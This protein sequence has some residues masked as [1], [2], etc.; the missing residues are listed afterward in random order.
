M[1]SMGL[2]RFSP[3]I[4]QIQ[5][6][7]SIF[8]SNFEVA[9]SDML[10]YCNNLELKFSYLGPFKYLDRFGTFVTK[11]WVHDV[12]Q[13]AESLAS[14]G[15]EVYLLRFSGNVTL[16]S[17]NLMEFYRTV[18]HTDAAELFNLIVFLFRYKIFVFKVVDACLFIYVIFMA[19]G[20]GSISVFPMRFR[21]QERTIN[22]R[23]ISSSGPE[24]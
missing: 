16:W 21:I 8:S 17:I 19:P 15:Q 9:Y 12:K 24:T 14:T 2:L 11:L 10:W 7:N 5:V 13:D 3:I 22:C 20:S 18:L 1:L 6:S 4:Y 23:S